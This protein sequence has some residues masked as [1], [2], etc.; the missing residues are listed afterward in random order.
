MGLQMI[1]RPNNC[2]NEDCQTEE[3]IK[4]K[5]FSI[6]PM[7]QIGFCLCI[8]FNKHWKR[9]ILDIPFLNITYIKFKDE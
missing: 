9:I 1:I 3:Q 7:I 2:N 5:D 4:E 6:T 8:D